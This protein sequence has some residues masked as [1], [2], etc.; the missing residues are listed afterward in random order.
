MI[1][2]SDDTQRRVVASFTDD[3]DRRHPIYP[4]SPH[5]RAAG[6]D[7]KARGRRRYSGGSSGVNRFRPGVRGRG[8]LQE[9]LEEV[10]ENGDEPTDCMTILE[11]I[12]S[13]P[14]L[15][16]LSDAISDLPV[17]RDA[18]DAKNETDTFFAPS[19]DAIEGFTSWAGFND[20]RAGLQELLG[21]TEWK[22]YIVAYH[23]VPDEMY[24]VDK[25][26]SLEGGDKFLEDALEAEM[27]LLYVPKKYEVVGMG[28]TA[29]IVGKNMY[30][31]NGVL[32]IIDTVLLPFD[33]RVVCH[34]LVLFFDLA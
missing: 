11:I 24:T 7:K 10:V 19:N 18:L 8:L 26:E 25:L 23:A 2:F 3:A 32:H 28:S 13:H 5:R 27:P 9:A 15:T 30:A 4:V 31:C 12:D 33:G 22:G 29:T 34:C 21:D 20:T 6:R 14:D 16:E 1:F 17:F